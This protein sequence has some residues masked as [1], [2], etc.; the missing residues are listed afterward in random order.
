MNRKIKFQR[1]VRESIQ[2]HCIDKNLRI[3]STALECLQEATEAY[4]VDIF[5]NTQYCAIHRKRITITAN[6]WQLTK[7]IK[8]IQQ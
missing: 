2:K 1:L 3:Q 4:L 5:K 8:K 7:R 6:D